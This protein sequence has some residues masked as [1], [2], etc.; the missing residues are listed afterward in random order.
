MNGGQC[1][2]PEPCA[3]SL[4][5]YTD[6]AAKT[7][8]YLVWPDARLR[9]YLRNRGVSEDAIPTSRPGLL[10]EVRIRWVQVTTSAESLI[11]RVADIFNSNLHYAEE[12]IGDVLA[13]LTG[14][15]RSAE[16]SASASYNEAKGYAQEKAHDAQW[17][18]DSAGYEA[19]AQWKDAKGSAKSAAA[20]ASGNVRATKEWAQGKAQSATA[21]A[22][23]ATAYAKHEL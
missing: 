6:N 7:A 20:Q 13:L 21:E 14:T 17:A 9:A 15:A 1:W 2:M 8:S 23:K 10:Q 4:S 18:A 11:A 5:Q 16:D 22:E 3:D 12:K 19:K